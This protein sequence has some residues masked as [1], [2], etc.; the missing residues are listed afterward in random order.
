[1]SDVLQSVSRAIDCQHAQAW[2]ADERTGQLTLGQAWSAVSEAVSGSA[3]GAA[4]GGPPKVQ[5]ALGVLTHG[6]GLLDHVCRAVGVV[7]IADVSREPQLV[8][9]V[10]SLSGVVGMAVAVPVAAGGQVLGVLAFFRAEAGALAPAA[11]DWLGTIGMQVAAVAARW[12]SPAGVRSNDLVRA[13][14]A[15]RKARMD[16]ERLAATMDEFVATVSHEL[17]TP[18]NAILGWTQ[19]LRRAKSVEDLAEP[20][21]V[22]ERNAR[23][24]GR[25]ISDLL[26]ISRVVGG[27]V[28]LDTAQ[29]QL[30][31]VVES[32]IDTVLPTASARRVR[33]QTDI[34]PYA[35]PV[36]GDAARLQQVAVNLL[37]NAIKFS[38]EGGVVRVNVE[39]VDGSVMLVVSDDGAGIPPEQIARVFERFSNAHAQANRR[40]PGLG[41]GLAIVKHLVE[42]HGGSVTAQSAG[43]GQGATFTVTLPIAVL[44]DRAPK[45]EAGEIKDADLSDA[46]DLAGASVLVVDDEP[47][48]LSFVSHVLRDKGADVATASSMTQAL[49]VLDQRSVDVLVS[50]I[51]MPEHDGYELIHRVRQRLPDKGGLVRALALTAFAREMDLRRALSAGFNMHVAKPVDADHLLTAVGRLL[52]SRTPR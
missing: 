2:F 5:E 32:A 30:D 35:G 41:L 40:H 25:L 26:D 49:A 38:R 44:F 8:R 11:L 14:A 47:D 37:S 21:A 20:V 10:K 6:V 22:I 28:T 24:Q 46:P 51:A 15:E 27:T 18:L 4:S 17:R 1:M 33:I 42:L 3:S 19:L 7:Q 12:R 9:H 43:E 16:S 45:R 29:I 50:D 13:L 31:Q 36:L 34:E 39:A 48:A 23:A 52:R